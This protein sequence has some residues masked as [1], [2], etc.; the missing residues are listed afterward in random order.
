MRSASWLTVRSLAL[1][2]R[3]AFSICTPDAVIWPPCWRKGNRFPSPP[4]SGLLDLRFLLRRHGLLHLGWKFLPSFLPEAVHPS[5]LGHVCRD[6][7]IVGQD[8][9]HIE[10]H[11]L[12]AVLTTHGLLVQARVRG[13][14]V[15]VAHDGDAVACPPSYPRLVLGVEISTA[16]AVR[17]GEQ[18]GERRHRAAPAAELHELQS[19]PAVVGVE[20]LLAVEI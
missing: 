15:V 7:G 20:I 3:F 17:R 8:A 10:G 6:V 11:I 16:Q 13:V 19:V 5:V 12:P 18:D 2:F 14:L 1:A 4:S 9:H